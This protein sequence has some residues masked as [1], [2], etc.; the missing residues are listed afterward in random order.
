MGEAALAHIDPF[1]LRRML[2]Q[3]RVG[4]RIG[5]HHLRLLVR[6]GRAE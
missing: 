3:R 2:A 1:G 4:Q 6:S 5:Q